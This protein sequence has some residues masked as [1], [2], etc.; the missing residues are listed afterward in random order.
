MVGFQALG[1]RTRRLPAS[2][3]LRNSHAPSAGECNLVTHITETT[4]AGLARELAEAGTW[5][6]DRDSR[7]QVG[8]ASAAAEP[9]LLLAGWRYRSTELAL[10]LTGPAPP[11]PPASVT[12]TAAATRDDWEQ[13]GR[14]LRMDHEEEAATEGRVPV[15]PAHT[16]QK[17]ASLRAKAPAARYWIARSA[18]TP[19]GFVA[20]WPGH[21]DMGMVEDLFVHPDHRRRGIATRML[22]HAVADARN[23]A[24]TPPEGPFPV[25]IRA[26]A[27][28]EPKHL[29]H[30]LGFEPAAVLR[31]YQG[32]TGDGPATAE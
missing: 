29:Y 24:G 30:R 8:P 31:S 7:I 2:R 27:D 1:A 12:L 4:P 11:L 15:P 23:R 26:A 20:S 10:V 16:R 32:P 9:A 25:L 3:C 6:G 13:L 14:L 17:L 28:D 19:C 22:G 5:L 21:G 18:G